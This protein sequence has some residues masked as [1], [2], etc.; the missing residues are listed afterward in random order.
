[1]MYHV[2]WLPPGN[3]TFA[4]TMHINN[5]GRKKRHQT[6]TILQLCVCV[7]ARA[8]VCVRASARLLYV[9]AILIDKH[10][11]NMIYFNSHIK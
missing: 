11:R 10:L 6:Q 9:Y 3:K 5:Q 8:C 4:T 2:T 1:M 7:R